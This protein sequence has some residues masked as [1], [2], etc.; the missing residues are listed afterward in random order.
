MSDFPDPIAFDK[1]ALLTVGEAYEGPEGWKNWIFC[2][3]LGQKG[4]WVPLQIIEMISGSAAR[5]RE[6]YTARELN[7]RPGEAVIGERV[8]NGWVWCKKVDSLESGWVPLEVLQ[9]V[10]V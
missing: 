6:D 7:V 1:G 3:S 5:A 4:G 8:L 10:N 2:E 9:E